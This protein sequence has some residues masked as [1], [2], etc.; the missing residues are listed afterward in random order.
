MSSI[1]G[2]IVKVDPLY[3]PPNMCSPEQNFTEMLRL[4]T[5]VVHKATRIVAERVSCVRA[6]D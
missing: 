3:K 6:D 2:P 1:V 5:L 4:R